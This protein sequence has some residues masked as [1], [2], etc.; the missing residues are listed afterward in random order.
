MIRL[1]TK[2]WIMIAFV[3]I[4]GLFCTSHAASMSKDEAQRSLQIGVKQLLN[5]NRFDELGTLFSVVQQKYD[6][7]SINEQDLQSTFSAFYATDPGLAPKFDSWIAKYPQ[8]YVAHLA[9]GIYYKRVGLKQRAEDSIED[10]GPGQIQ[11]MESAFRKSSKDLSD[12]FAMDDKPLLSYLNS[13]SISS[14]F[15]NRQESR[16][17]LDL[18]LKIDPNTFVVRESYMVTLQ[19]RWG[20]SLAQMK[21]FLHECKKAHLSAVHIR[22]L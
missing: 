5:S 8:S 18:S 10:A 4:H 3:A 20:G 22:E 1:S 19:T 2:V 9:R 14:Y 15:G 16:T 13:I 21:A 7:G 11:D 12:S 6:A 17:L